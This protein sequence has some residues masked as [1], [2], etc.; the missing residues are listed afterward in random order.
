MVLEICE[1]C[2]FMHVNFTST[3]DKTKT[4]MNM[5]IIGASN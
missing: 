3:S 1:M 2:L 5:C 4:N